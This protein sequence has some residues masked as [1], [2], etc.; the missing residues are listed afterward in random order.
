MDYD[1]FGDCSM[2]ARAQVLAS[3]LV[4]CILRKKRRRCRC[5]N[6]SWD[7]DLSCIQL[8]FQTLNST[9]F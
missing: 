6:P 8:A 4:L 2:T 7:V 9:Y 5:L 3:V 1:G